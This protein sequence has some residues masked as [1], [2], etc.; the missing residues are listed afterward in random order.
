M[1]VSSLKKLIRTTI[2]SNQKHGVSKV[3]QELENIVEEKPLTGEVWANKFSQ[4]NVMIAT[5]AF[6]NMI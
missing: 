2:A 1:I 6:G 4:K 5:M 3:F